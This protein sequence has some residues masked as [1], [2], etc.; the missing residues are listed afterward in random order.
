MEI[1]TFINP[2][3]GETL[4]HTRREQRQLRIA[5]ARMTHYRQSVEMLQ[6]M[7]PSEILTAGSRFLPRRSFRQL[8]RVLR[9]HEATL[10]RTD[11][12]LN[13]AQRREAAR[14]N[15]H[16]RHVKTQ[17]TVRHARLSPAETKNV[18]RFL[19]DAEPSCNGA[20]RRNLAPGHR[21][22]LQSQA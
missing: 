14:R 10:L 21:W 15:I 12:S 7:R 17:S 9:K 4:Q 3:T 6:H 13:R 20:E 22:M 19:K 1:P 8:I 16:P 5:L 2:A 18:E 11:K